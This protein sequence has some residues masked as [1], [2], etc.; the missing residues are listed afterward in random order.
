[1]C[2]KDF[3]ET[4]LLEKLVVTFPEFTYCNSIDFAEKFENCSV[5][6]SGKFKVKMKVK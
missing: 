2:L 4:F 1:M 6:S 3:S 5:E